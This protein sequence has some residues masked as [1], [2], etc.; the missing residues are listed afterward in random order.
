MP[1]TQPPGGDHCGGD[2]LIGDNHRK[3]FFNLAELERW[4]LTMK[5]RPLLLVIAMISGCAA[6]AISEAQVC[7]DGE[8]PCTGAYGNGCIKPNLDQVCTQGL[9]CNKDEQPCAGAYG[10]GCFKSTLDQSCTQGLICNKDEQP[11]TGAYGTGCIKPGLDQFCAQ[12]L[13]CNKGQL[14]CFT[15]GHVQCY[16][17]SQGQ[18][19]N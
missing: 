14:P 4:R 10:A 17:P 12:G 16:T 15:N 19:C 6:A 11:C 18:S 5:I 3:I 7:N 9:I 8:Q 1:A 13:I 2:A